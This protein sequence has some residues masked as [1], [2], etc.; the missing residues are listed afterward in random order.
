MKSILRLVFFKTSFVSFSCVHLLSVVYTLC[1]P[2]VNNPTHLDLP[3]QFSLFSVITSGRR[4][5]AF[6]RVNIAK[7]Y[8]QIKN[9]EVLIC[10][11]LMLAHTRLFSKD[12]C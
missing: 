2:L 9:N 11:A 7:C 4:R 5:F 1:A 12:V 3:V 10:W 8:R 6:Q